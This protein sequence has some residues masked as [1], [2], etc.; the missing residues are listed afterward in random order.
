MSEAADAH[1]RDITQVLERVSDGFFAVDRDWR[2]TY[3]NERAEDL[4]Q[5]EAESLLE[6]TLWEAFPRAV[7]TRFEAEYRRAMET[8][9]P[10]SFDAG[11][12]PLDAHFEVHAYPSESGLSVYFRDVS[13]RHEREQ[14][15]K[16]Y[17]ATL[18]TIGDGAYALDGDRRFVFVNEALCEMTGYD[19][20]ELLGEVSTRIISE[21]T[22]EE[23]GDQV[24][25]LLAGDRDEAVLES[26]IKTADGGSFWAETRFRLRP[27]DGEF[28]GTVGI[29]RDVTERR[30][31]QEQLEDHRDKLAA[32]VDR[33]EV[34]Q[35]INRRIV[36]ATSRED[37]EE[38]VC[39]TL[40]E[41]PFYE[42]AWIGDRERD[43]LVLR[44]GV[45]RSGIGLE[46]LVDAASGEHEISPVESA[47]RRG[48][49]QVLQNVDDDPSD[50]RREG[51]EER[52]IQASIS[53]PLVHEGTSFG[54]LTIDAERPHAF[55]G[56]ERDLL[57][58]LADTVAYAL[59]AVE[60]RERYRSVVTDVLDTAV[61][62]GIVI[63]D[64]DDRI[65]WANQRAGAF[66]GFDP[67]GV[68]GR[69]RAQFLREYYLPNV[70]DPTDVSL[71]R[72]PDCRANTGGDELHVLGKGDLTER[73]LER[74]RMPIESGL[75][76]G[77][78]V[79]LFYDITNRKETERS[80]AESE[81]LRRTLLSN[82]PGM[83]YQCRYEE[84][85]PM[86]FVSDGC[87]DLTG[88]DA[89]AIERGEVSY[90]A[91]VIHED[92]RE[93]V[94]ATIDRAVEAGDAF[95]LTYRIHHADGAERWVWEKGQ[96]VETIEGEHRL[97]GFVTDITEQKRQ[98]RELEREHD[99][100]TRILDT[101]PVGI[102]AVDAGGVVTMANDRAREIL[103]ELDIDVDDPGGLFVEDGD[104]EVVDTE[105][106]HEV[107]DFG[108]RPPSDHPVSGV[109]ETG[110][111]VTGVELEIVG[112]D[113][114]T[115]WLSVSAAPI[116]RGDGD[117]DG[118][119][120]AFEDVTVRRAR[121]QALTRLD[122][123]NAV[124]RRINET[125][126]RSPDRET[127]QDTVCEELA[128]TDQYDAA[129][130]A[131]VD[132]AED[133]LQVVSASGV[134]VDDFDHAN[135]SEDSVTGRA[136]RSGTVVVGSVEGDGETCELFP[137]DGCT[138]DP[139]VLAAVPI[140][141][142]NAQ[143]GVL[144]LCSSEGSA[145]STEVQEVFG[146][147]GG[148]IGHAINAHLRKEGLV[149]DAA[150]RLEF[151]LRD[152][153]P[154]GFELSEESAANESALDFEDT[155]SLGDGSVLQYVTAR[156]ISADSLTDLVNAVSTVEEVRELSSRDGR[157]RYELR[158]SNPPVVETLATHGGRVVS[159]A[160]EEGDLHV[161]AELPDSADVRD[162]V[163]QVLESYPEADLEA[164]RSVA[165][166]ESSPV[167][168]RE[169]VLS[170]LTDRQRTVLEV[171]YLAGYFEWPRAT[172]GEEVAD[173][174]D[175]SQ[176]TFSQHLRAGEGKTF[177]LLFDAGGADGRDEDRSLK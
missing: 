93:A 104:Y 3:V 6:T 151:R 174:L 32:L 140:E 19:R 135:A 116:G 110:D 83:V 117:P 103:D 127:I 34:V 21:E 13:D 35:E 4:I 123:L 164:Q 14:R 71:R 113:G 22:Y 157:T 114:T 167:R 11:F 81:R 43:E 2:F 48:T 100:R 90:G 137:S 97:E 134:D 39:R 120:A 45:D 169:D 132:L 99:L 126:V 92:D 55:S 129:W 50:P 51:F 46:D 80:L 111:P 41:S 106:R 98:E 68:T 101:S 175:V 119:V 40:A 88:Y 133:E 130:Y 16:Q 9:E 149:S 124:I 42:V 96:R 1:E 156:G 44:T 78:C 105:L 176:A 161:V 20:D 79:K 150:T 145:F 29:I 53:L 67:E 56:T 102:A 60:E 58:S 141:Y 70:A 26:P 65:A 87:R 109:L 15:L 163:E 125:L 38:T 177:E 118:V 17:R 95:E 7:D 152:F 165:R 18:E 143:Y 69:S 91:D 24:Q 76:A 112:A 131:E 64:E 153:P 66:F 128:R 173:S 108:S 170:G 144:G 148:I 166:T 85:W 5:R 94:R 36:S 168:F 37:V 12:D 121:E 8:Q 162:V 146:E 33:T 27:G 136:V 82:L 31:R 54:V 155:I 154:G 122:H 86:E 57:A 74:R 61:D 59:R 73:H 25:A 23:A 158:Q 139:P 84:G 160:I 147:L 49:I 159:I 171:A 107:D 72:S 30:R 47:L 89:G 28:N 10:I 62:A 172:T 142:A 75:Y 138:G 52:G 63:V 115:H 77:G